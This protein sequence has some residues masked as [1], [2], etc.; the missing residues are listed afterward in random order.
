MAMANSHRIIDRQSSQPFSKWPLTLLLV[1]SAASSAVVVGISY[2]QTSTKN[3]AKVRVDEKG[4]KFVNNIPFDVF[5]DNPLEIVNSNKGTVPAVENVKTADTPKQSPT[6]PKSTN[7]G[8]SAAW[9]EIVPMEELQTELKAVRN[10]LK[11]GLTNPKSY[12]SNME[13]ISIDGAEMAALAGIV[14][15]HPDNVTWKPNAKYVREFGTQINESAIGLGKENFEKTKSAFQKLNSVLDG[16]IPA[17]AGDVPSERP[18]HEAA[19][20][21]KLMKRISKAKDWL[22]Q[23]PN[24]EAKFRSLGAELRHEAAII[25]AFGTVISTPGYDYC[26]EP[27][28]QKHAKT[29]IDGAKEATAASQEDS[30]ER[31]QQAVNKVNKSCTDCHALYGN[32]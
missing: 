19:S 25:T 6:T 16:S 20:R 31:F 8:T 24:N 12:S 29:L 27:E 14:Q 2:A 15:L 1:V 18:F 32:G 10:R 7:Q 28:F 26:D 13:L 30:Y 3:E 5:F 11:S 17:D 4:R 9:N 23:E 22:K 21:N